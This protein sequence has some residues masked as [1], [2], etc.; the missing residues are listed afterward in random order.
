M[1]QV[2]IL[3]DK[4]KT[5]SSYLGKKPFRK[6]R[7]FFSVDV[8]PSGSGPGHAPDNAQKSGLSRSAWAFD[9]GN[10]VQLDGHTD[11]VYG[12]EPVLLPIVVQTISIKTLYNI[13]Q[14]NFILDIRRVMLNHG[15]FSFLNKIFSCHGVHRCTFW[16]FRMSTARRSIK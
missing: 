5:T 9:N 12:R 14:F 16:T 3:R 15:R 13:E 7:D 10:A 2:E 4:S 6:A 8:N 1:D 11:P